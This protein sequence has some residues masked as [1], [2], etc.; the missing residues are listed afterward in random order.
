[1]KWQK[2]LDHVLISI[3]LINFIAI[4]LYIIVNP[5]AVEFNINNLMIILPTFL[6]IDFISI[7]ILF[8]LSLKQI[9]DQLKAIQKHIWVIL[10]LLMIL[11]ISISVFLVPTVHRILFDED[12]YLQI[13]N[14]VAKEG[15]AIFC[16]H[17]TQERCYEGFLN[18]EPNGYPVLM[19]VVF[20]F[21]GTSE[22]LA[23]NFSLL[24]GTLSIAI[25]FLISYLLSKKESIGLWSSL[26]LALTPSY[27][28]WSRSISVE[29]TFVFLSLLTIFVFLLYFRIKTLRMLLLGI[30]LLAFTVQIRPESV[31]LVPVIFLMFLLF[32]K[33][34]KNKIFDYNFLALWTLFIVLI[35]P[36]MLHMYYE[37]KA[38]D[39]GAPQGKFDIKYLDYNFKI[40][41]SFWFNNKFHPLL[42]TIFS[43]VG[44]IYLL[45]YNRRIILFIGFWF[46]IFFGL[47]LVFYSG[48]FESGGIGTR[49][50]MIV[51][52]PVIILGGYGIYALYHILDKLIKAPIAKNAF[53]I[54]ILTIML[55]S[56]YPFI[57]FISTP[58]PQ[59]NSAR[60]EHDLADRVSREINN[61]CVVLTHNPGMLIVMGKEA[62]QVR[63]AY[64]PKV[65]KDIFKR[66]DCVF[67]IEGYWCNTEPHKSSVCKFIHDN[68]NLTTYARDVITM[69]GNINWTL[70]AYRVGPR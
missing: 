30:L 20:F 18:K 51:Y 64:D 28:M 39:W 29:L 2:T 52:P 60:G 35:A 67:F 46:M 44:T 40:N 1:M 58:E 8:F 70:T 47:Y 49:F 26:I 62:L 6:I 37:N 33:N 31:L 25:I 9:L 10:I 19:G 38:S 12:I 15:R 7:V 57:S 14:H 55:L 34:L 21:F 65:M 68:Y 69:P 5:N 59:A 22:N 61:S 45:V 23:F 66:T 53:T 17:G 4:L 16:D 32:D 56:F 11:Q 27:L 13:A 54:F 63:Y 48:S 41:S 42:F 24:M 3:I 43:V 36:H 50:A